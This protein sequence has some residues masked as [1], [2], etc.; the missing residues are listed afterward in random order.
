MAATPNM[1][2][3]LIRLNHVFFC[4]KQQ[5]L[6]QQK[7]AIDYVQL[8]KISHFSG[9]S[10]TKN[11]TF[12][13]NSSPSTNSTSTLNSNTVTPS[14]E[15]PSQAEQ[16]TTIT[17]TTTTAA[18]A[19]LNNSTISSDSSDIPN[20]FPNPNKLGIT[21]PIHRIK[22]FNKLNPLSSS[23]S[24]TTTSS[25]SPSFFPMTSSH[26]ITSSLMSF[27]KVARQFGFITP[28]QL[29]T[30]NFH[31]NNTSSSSSSSSYM[32]DHSSIPT[33]PAP[34]H[35]ILFINAT[36]NN[37]IINLTHPNGNI[38]TWATPGTVGFKKHQ[39]SS[40]DAAHLAMKQ[41][42]EKTNSKKIQIKKLHVKLSG[43]GKGRDA[44]LKAI[45]SNGW[46]IIRL[47]DVTPIAFNGCRPPKRRRV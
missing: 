5:L 7:S 39:R 22:P 29:L 43:F 21:S 44:C 30:P 16:P 27:D 8:M 13:N 6:Q 35:H 47:T 31:F 40:A 33:T 1:R 38:I 23:T 14:N 28:P 34:P 2:T 25:S 20:T 37:T 11:Q 46:D 19:E 4:Q 36:H 26:S 3:S 32:N 12:E 41:L 24:S 10:M 17:P 18:A 9:T 45:K 15:N 42:L